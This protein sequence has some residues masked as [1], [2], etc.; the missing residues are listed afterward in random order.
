MTPPDSIKALLNAYPVISPQVVEWGEMDVARIVNNTVYGR[1]SENA[2]GAYFRAW[3]PEAFAR[4]KVNAHRPVLGEL[5][6]TYISSVSFPD[7]VWMGTRISEIGSDR[8]IMETLMISESSGRAVAKAKGK[9]VQFD[10]EKQQ[11]AALPEDFET[12]VQAFEEKLL[13]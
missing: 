6:I 9:L 10:F 11:K 2:R 4:N 5:E 3:K 8:Y 13:R 7:T 12:Q 1:W